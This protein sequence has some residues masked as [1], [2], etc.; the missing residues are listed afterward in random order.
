MAGARRPGS[1]SCA[2]SREPAQRPP[3]SDGLAR[4]CHSLPHQAEATYG[5]GMDNRTEVRDF[6][7]SRRA[8]LTP[9]QAGL[10]LYGATVASPAYAA[11]RLLSSP[12]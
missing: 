8:R 2:T 7:T 11:K 6:L 10:P 12:T 9:Q 4:Y 5:Q 1:A 3:G